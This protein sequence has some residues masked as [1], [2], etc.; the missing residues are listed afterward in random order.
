MRLIATRILTNALARLRR[1]PR[2]EDGFT[3]IAALGVL[4]IT[5]VLVTT[6]F[7]A[8][9]GDIN[10]TQHDLD[11]K[12]AYFA[13]RGGVNEFLH[14][15]KQDP[16]Y[17]DQCPSQTAT[18]VPGSTVQDDLTYAYVP[19]P[20]NDESSCVPNDAETM[21]DNDT[22]TFRMRFTG[23]SR[24]SSRSLV[25][26]FR[27]DSPLD[28]LW[29]TVYEVLDPNTQ[30]LAQQSAYR[31]RCEKFH[32]ENRDNSCNIQFISADF[33]KG[34]M[35]T[36][37]QF[38]TC[39]SPTFGRD[40]GD[41]IK[42]MRSP[43]HYASCSG[44]AGGPGTRVPNAALVDLPPAN[45]ALRDDAVAN[46]GLYKGPTRI[47]F[48]VGNTAR[49]TNPAAG[50]NNAVINLPPIIYVETNTLVGCTDPPYSPY[51]V[52]YTLSGG[53]GNVY[54]SG[55]YSQPTT[56]AATNDIIIEGNIT[57][58]SLNG[59]AMLGLVAK[60]FVR[61]KH[62][63]D[64]DPDLPDPTEIDAA[65]L[66]LNHSFIVDNYNCGSRLGTLRIRGAI[67]QYFRGTVG[68]HSGSQ[69]VSGYV[70]DYEYDDRLATRTPPYLFDLNEASWRIE[71]ETLCVLGG[72]DTS[73]N[74]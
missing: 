56:I 28:F 72:S 74:C 13:A 42:S 67:A 22:G 48:L 8:A 51:N 64:C 54:V 11:N 33:M 15:L 71:R 44:T 63:N 57:A 17:W 47:Q 29:Y 6:A 41:E 4:T 26:S 37:D 20:A 62:D 55:Q 1:L 65:I 30:P 10:L 18:P 52:T 35:F 53:C 7:V 34:P 31:T 69:V 23:T 59:P 19:V 12:R 27:R 70:K 46:N 66:A 14:H 61:V 68:T 36:Q 73:T 2:S 9:E 60:N 40:T 49:V 32:Y 38:S 16:N 45:T 58:S 24:D 5:S 25:A 3:M 43:V 39:G 21:I 50:L